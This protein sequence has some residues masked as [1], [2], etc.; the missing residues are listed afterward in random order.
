MGRLQAIPGHSALMGVI[1][2]RGGTGVFAWE[3]PS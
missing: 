3:V 2:V 1:E